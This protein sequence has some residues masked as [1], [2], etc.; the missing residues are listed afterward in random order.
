[1]SA[2]TLAPESVEAVARRVADLLRGEEVGGGELIDAAEVARRFGVS[3]TFVYRHAARLGAVRLGDGPRAR[4]RFDPSTVS[5]ALK[6][7][8]P[9]P[10]TSTRR[11][12]TTERGSVELLPV[13]GGGSS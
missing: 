12:R 8:E 4:L 13:H 3:T 9:S 6:A 7:A 5:E 1:M 2:V 10:P 11:R